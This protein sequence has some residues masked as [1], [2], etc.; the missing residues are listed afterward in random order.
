MLASKS[1][2]GLEGVIDCAD[3]FLAYTFNFYIANETKLI[4]SFSLAILNKLDRVLSPIS[5]NLLRFGR[6][7]FLLRLHSTLFL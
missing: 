1:Y 2:R 3:L 4:S 6:L 7:A 5:C